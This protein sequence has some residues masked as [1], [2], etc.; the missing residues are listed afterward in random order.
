LLVNN[1]QGRHDADMASVTHRVDDELKEELDAFCQKHGLKQQAVV[2]EAIA[3]W[4]ED[5]ADAAL[6]D[7]RRAGPWI[8]WNDVKDKL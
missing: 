1:L 5:A 8:E 2:Q 6:V 4:L 7:E 3:C